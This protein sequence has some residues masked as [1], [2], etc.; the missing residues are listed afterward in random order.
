MSPEDF[1]LLASATRS[2]SSFAAAINEIAEAIEAG[3]I[4]NVVLNDAKH[5][6]SNAAYD[7]WRK[8]VQEPFFYRGMYETHFQ[9]V[10][11]LDNSISILGLH[12]V[13]ATSRKLAK[14]KIHSAA[15]DAMRSFV[16]E[17]LPLA[18]AVASLKDKVVK[19]RAPSAG[20]SKPVNPNKVVKTC[21]CCF[22][23]IAVQNGTM[24]HHGY[25][26][27]GT[28]WQTA[29]CPGVRFKPLEVSSEGLE[30]LI[31][32]LRSKLESARA[33]HKDR[34]NKTSLSVL[35]MRKLVE[36][37]KGSPEWA[38]EFKRFVAELEFEISGLERELPILDARLRD[39]SPEVSQ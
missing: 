1:P 30:W 15:V 21:P 31:S 11:D 37:T 23:P 17:V 26:R 16:N 7:G 8:H 22:R 12:D 39:W 35:K 14:V 18:E 38:R 33:S 32:A 10:I 2:A 9:D 25:E 3:A 36:V 20:P 5:T 29:S 28:G 13:L 24:A 19:G 6:L 27:P 34:A 4:R